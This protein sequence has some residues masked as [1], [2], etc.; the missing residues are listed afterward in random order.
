MNKEQWGRKLTC[1]NCGVKFYDLKKKTI[2][3]P[4]CDAPYK[5]EKVKSR[6]SI[7]AEIP[8]P[9]PEPAKDSESEEDLL[10]VKL[11]DDILDAEDD[12]VQ[13]VTIME[14]TS[15]IGGDDEDIGEVIGVVE[16]NGEKE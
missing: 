2:T 13:D 5:V 11:D 10:E 4:K 15:D 1:S 8:K 9:V 6:R 7:T 3:C 14:D 12:K 16:D